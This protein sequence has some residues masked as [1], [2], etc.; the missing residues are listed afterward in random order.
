MQ[1]RLVEVDRNKNEVWSYQRPQQDMVRAKRLP[2]G[3]VAFITNQGVGATFTRMDPKTQKVNKS[4]T[5]GQVSMLFG[6]WEVL[7]NGHILVPHY[8]QASV[9]EYDDN[10]KQVGNPFVGQQWPNSAARLSN[11]NTL[12]AS[13]NIRKVFEYDINRN[14]VWNYDTVGNVF[15]ARKR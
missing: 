2:S 14:Q 9:I 15:V 1:G 8:N 12:I 6:N 7:P 5:I 13:Q 3:E 4:F 10:G 11:G